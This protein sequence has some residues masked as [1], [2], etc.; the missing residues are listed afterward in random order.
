MP[1]TPKPSPSSPN[2]C[3]QK[4]AP[5]TPTAYGSPIY[6][7]APMTPPN[8]GSA[9]TSPP[10][11]GPTPTKSGPSQ[12]PR[13]PPGVYVHQGLNEPSSSGLRGST[14]E[15]G[16]MY[17]GPPPPPPSGPRPPKAPP[18]TLSQRK[19]SNYSGSVMKEGLVIPPNPT[20]RRHEP[21][22]STRRPPPS[23]PPTRSTLTHTL[24]LSFRPAYPQ[25]RCARV[26][27]GLICRTSR[28]RLP[29]QSVRRHIG[30]SRLRA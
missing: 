10:R 30:A 8:Y 1:G 25:G 12:A 29:R 13:S 16:T 17:V 18:P 9:S 6:K 28:L 22:T 26:V 24:S 3:W 4:A 11:Y 23:K 14:A 2:Q 20:M 15:V 5:T 19:E 27:T 21:K 7:A